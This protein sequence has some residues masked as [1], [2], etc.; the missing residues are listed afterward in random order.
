MV[1]Y[2]SANKRSMRQFLSFAALMCFFIP[3]FAQSLSVESF[4]LLEND[5]TANTFG[6]IERDQNGEVAALIKVVTIE[7]GFVFDGGMLGIVKTEQKTGEIWVYVPAGLQ[8][9]TVS[10]QQLGV[11][12]DYYFPISV[13]K[14]RTYEMRLL[15]GRVRT[16]VEDE[17]TAQYAI[18]T[19]EPRNAVVYI[20]GI[21]YTAQSDGTVTQLLEY[22]SHE[23]RVE[24]YGYRSEAGTIQVGSEKVLRNIKLESTMAT[25]TIQCSMPEADI[26]IN[27]EKVGTGTWTGQLIPAI[28][29]VESKRDYYQTRVQTLTVKESEVRTI[30]IPE[31]LQQYGRLQVQS[32]PFNATVF[33]DGVELGTT[34]LIK[35]DLV[36][37]VHKMVLK[38]EDYLDYSTE[39]VV[40]GSEIT[41]IS[42]SLKYDV[43]K[44]ARL[45]RQKRKE[46]KQ[47]QKANRIY[48]KNTD[49]YF[50]MAMN[51]NWNIDPSILV[52]VGAD[53]YG[54]NV[55]FNYGVFEEMESL[56]FRGYWNSVK[57]L[58]L[59]GDGKTEGY[60][61][62]QYIYGIESYMSCSLGYGI[63]F[64]KMFRLTPQVGLSSFQIKGL[65]DE[66]VGAFGDSG[67]R[68]TYVMCVPIS[69][70]CEFSPLRHVSLVYT[71]IVSIPVKYGK[72]A[73]KLNE[74]DN[75]LS[76]SVNGLWHHAGLVVYF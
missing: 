55:E 23:Y 2:H 19:V 40:N 4:R 18:F 8:K 52:K 60:R 11:L 54:L 27:D 13:E 66:S 28:Y 9:I 10:H 72:I 39:L 65:T 73:T 22:G 37:G 42:A 24:L 51:L 50:G 71:P 46:E 1:S 5:L 21:A 45:E 14:A 58:D 41:E 56:Y 20:D 74:K 26:Y 44:Q 69:V 43:D 30:S 70:K 59:N 32:T 49:F 57:P 29:K 36:A 62:Y 7:T 35:G 63:M 75:E 38:L 12:R 48:L 3:A 31:P 33:L 68:S 67:D 16:V 64:K 25:I 53:F 47:L 17:F 34:P 61:S 15:S 6:T 76:G